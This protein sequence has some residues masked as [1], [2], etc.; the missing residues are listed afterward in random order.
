MADALDPNPTPGTIRHT[1]GE[2]YH[3]RTADD[4]WLQFKYDGTKPGAALAARTKAEEAARAIL[5]PPAAALTFAEALGLLINHADALAKSAGRACDILADDA[6]QG[7]GKF[8]RVFEHDPRRP[9]DERSAFCFVCRAD[10]F[11]RTLGAW[12]QGDVLKAAGWKCPA[13]GTRG[14]IMAGDPARYGINAY[15]A[16]YANGR[17]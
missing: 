6:D 2:C 1:S 4:A 17:G 7:A 8:V 3:V 13:K 16:N 15:G 14:N 12:K 11:N 5:M 9:A 10:G